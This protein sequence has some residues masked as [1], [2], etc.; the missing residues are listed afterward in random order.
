MSKKQGMQY[1][2]ATAQYNLKYDEEQ[3]RKNTERAKREAEK[4]KK[5][6]TPTL[7]EKLAKKKIGPP[8]RLIYFVYW[9]L[10]AG[11][12]MKKYKPVIKIEDDINDCKGP[13]FLVWNH[14]S[15]LDHAYLMAAT[16]PKRL[17]IVAGYVEHFRSHLHTVFRL[18]RILPKKNF[19]PD[20][21]GVKAMN[22]IIMKGGTVCFAPEGVST[23]Y[24]DNQPI[25][26]GTGRFIKHYKIPV[27]YAELRGQ[28]LTCPKHWLEE[29]VSRTEVTLK[30]LFTPEQLAE[31][32][33]EEIEDKL[34]LTFKY[35]DY[36]WSREHGLKWKQMNGRAAAGYD[37]I[38]YK[39]PKCGKELTYVCEGDTLR[40]TECGNE[41][42]VDEYYQLSP[43]S[44]DS[45]GFED[46]VAWEKWERQQI[47]KEIREDPNYS[48]SC[49]CAIGCIPKYHYIEN[50]ATSEMCGKGTFT[51][52]HSGIHFK[53]TKFGEP[54]ELNAS[55]DEVFTLLIE[56]D[57]SYFSHY[58]PSGMIDFYPETKCV[59]K[60][61]LLTEEM[62]RLHKNT[63]KNFPW[64]DYMYEGMEL[65]SGD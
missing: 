41:V 46:P 13:C 32:T 54:F 5:K 3:V 15:R 2:P 19:A 35:N 12:I 9:F 44:A 18:N 38:F 49:E 27:Y 14:L 56:T 37:N 63:W 43:T 55:Y 25:V 50:M 29:R 61:V 24:G 65:P 59:T 20:L 40:C 62:H 53:G 28:A 39:C 4:A 22:S 8:S 64:N 26:P 42:M 57:L 52:D 31:M 58:F 1:A 48:Y 16:Y 51:I 30:L 36:E 10:M 21:P 34:N 33:A 45:I 23:L 6:G 47:I 7:H 60:L 11:F 17:S